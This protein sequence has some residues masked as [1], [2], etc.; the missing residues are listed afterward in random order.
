MGEHE[1]EIAAQRLRVG[2]SRLAP[3]RA[4]RVG[5]PVV[6][7]AELGPQRLP[8]AVRAAQDVGGGQLQRVGLERASSSSE[9]GIRSDECENIRASRSTRDAEELQ[10]GAAVQLQRAG[11]RVGADLR[12][13]SMS[14][15]VQ[16]P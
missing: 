7:E 16:L 4:Q 1:L 10:R 2:V 8:L 14:P 11:E 12:V 5:E 13:P 3:A 6:D 15:P 9:T